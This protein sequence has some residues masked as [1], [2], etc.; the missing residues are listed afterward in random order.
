MKK[1]INDID[2]QKH[3]TQQELLDYTQDV[4]GNDE[5]YRLELHLNECELCSEAVEG[6]VLLKNPTE[7]VETIHKSILPNY[8]K[9]NTTNYLAIASSIAL[10]AIFGLSYW[11]LNKSAKSPT[12][13][14][15]TGPEQ[16]EIA[17]DLPVLKEELGKKIIIPEQEVIQEELRIT[18]S[19]PLQLTNTN[20]VITTE[21][22]EEKNRDKVQKEEGIIP[23]NELAVNDRLKN[24]DN[25]ANTDTRLEETSVE[26]ASEINNNN[27]QSTPS[28]ARSAKKSINE[29][30]PPL[31]DQK[32]PAP[33]GGMSALKVFIDQNL[34]YPQEAIDNKIK[35]TVVLEVTVSPNGA[36]KNII[37]IKSVGAGCDAEAMRLIT[38]GPKWI[39][40]SAN[41]I[42]I[43]EKRQ[44]KIKFKN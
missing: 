37:I 40:A 9:K 15:N 10:I 22:D 16:T 3:L 6:I 24:N 17:K 29:P 4:L 38:A 1:Q 41:G 21:E 28:V 5:M 20:Q 19:E 11:L 2:L 44:V 8:N 33:Q 12:I 25:L 27:L 13:A 43:E 26:P 39:P 30:A 14:E 23:T 32:V 36:I 35:G 31:K 34:D 7:A 42:A 18:K